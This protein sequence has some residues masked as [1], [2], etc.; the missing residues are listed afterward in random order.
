MLMYCKST[1]K[2]TRNVG[3]LI[4]ALMSTDLKIYGNA[5]AKLVHKLLN[6]ETKI[7]K[8][9]LNQEI[10]FHSL[11]DASKNYEDEFKCSVEV[12]VAENSKEPKSKQALPGK[13]AILVE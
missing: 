2:K 1:R 8:V 13:A 11:N 9:V 12:I 6:D 4:K 7:P 5:I 10:E 3:A